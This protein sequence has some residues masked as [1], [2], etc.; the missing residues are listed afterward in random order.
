VVL[1]NISTILNYENV[2]SLNYSEFL[3]A[4]C[5]HMKKNIHSLLLMSELFLFSFYVCVVPLNV[6]FLPLLFQV[7][8][9]ACIEQ[10]SSLPTV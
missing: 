6:V 10:Q 4:S 8:L 1:L 7:N 3:I 2:L 9:C 5:K